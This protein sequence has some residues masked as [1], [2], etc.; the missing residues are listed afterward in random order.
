MDE[1]I[2][3]EW[4]IASPESGEGFPLKIRPTALEME[5]FEVTPELWQRALKAY[6][7]ARTDLIRRAAL[8]RDQAVSYRGFK[9]GCAAMGIE[10]PHYGGEERFI[11]YDGCNV[12]LSPAIVRGTDKRCA[13]RNTL[14]AMKG[15]AKV[16]NALV[17]VS[18]EAN[19][20]DEPR[21]HDVLHPCEDCRH[22]FREFLEEG[23]MREDTILCNVNDAEEELKIEERTLRDLLDL[24]ADDQVRSGVPSGYPVR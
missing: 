20:G 18:K 19:T 7:E 8:A 2:K 9:I 4:H 17:T 1:S 6:R 14:E 12:K 15:W 5:R 10:P 21:I 23:F 16:I 3:K 24:Y 11:G 13:E 22:L